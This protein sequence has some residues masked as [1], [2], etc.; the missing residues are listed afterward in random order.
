[1][2]GEKENPIK[3]HVVS[4]HK[5]PENKEV[6]WVVSWENENVITQHNTQEVETLLKRC[7]DRA[8]V[9]LKLSLIKSSS[10]EAKENMFQ[11]V[12]STFYFSLL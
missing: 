4:G 3:G 7:N 2:K 11:N 1:M 8:L 9:D 10:G 12:K 5:N 6:V